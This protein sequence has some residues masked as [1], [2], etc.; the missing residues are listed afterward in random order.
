MKSMILLAALALPMAAAAEEGVVSFEELIVKMSDGGK[1]HF[2]YPDNLSQRFAD[3]KVHAQ[4]ESLE[5]PSA[6][7]AGMEILKAAGMATVLQESGAIRIVLVESA[8]KEALRV[9]SS[10]AELPANDEFCSLAIVLRFGRTR[11]LLAPVQA[12]ISDPRNV[13]CTESTNSMIISDYASNLRKLAKIIERID[14]G[15]DATNWRITVAVLEGKDGVVSAPEGFDAAKLHEATGRTSFTFVGDG[16]ATLSMGGS[17]SDRG[18]KGV[19][20]VRLWGGEKLASNIRTSI[21]QD[22]SLMI[23]EFVILTDLAEGKT[24]SPLLQTRLG[25]KSG[26]WTVAGSL[27]GDGTSNAG[28]VVLV[29]AEPVK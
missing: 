10:V 25:V 7:A 17:A 11:D 19:A 12:L 8:G 23:D 14:V 26:V 2:L 9:I 16:M 13:V 6:F 4:A 3:R 21:A 18:G 28:R 22:G 15:Q 29:K 24:N 20:L 1:R 5:G 27:P